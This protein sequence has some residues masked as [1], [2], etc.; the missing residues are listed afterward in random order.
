MN[1]AGIVSTV[2][3]AEQTVRVTF[4]DRDNI[5]SGELPVL[6]HAWDD[7]SPPVVG[8]YALCAFTD[9]GFDK[10]FCVGFY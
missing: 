7:L 9:R 1:K 3:T 5:V 6:K 10:G 8:D 4:P 2:N